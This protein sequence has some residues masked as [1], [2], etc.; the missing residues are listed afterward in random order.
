MFMGE[1]LGRWWVL[2]GLD[3]DVVGIVGVQLLWELLALL[4]DPPAVV[5][6]G[7]LYVGWGFPSQHADTHIYRYIDVHV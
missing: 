3:T 5:A 4:R 6:G 1:A 2:W 7:S